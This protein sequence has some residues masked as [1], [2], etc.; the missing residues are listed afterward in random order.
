MIGISFGAGIPITLR[1]NAR[2]ELLSRVEAVA[3]EGMVRFAEGA[4]A[5]VPVWTGYTRAIWEGVGEYLSDLG[6]DSFP[7]IDYSEA[8]IWYKPYWPT[9]N[10]TDV[11]AEL[12]DEQQAEGRALGYDAV[13]I[14]RTNRSIAFDIFIPAPNTRGGQNYEYMEPDWDSLAAGEM[15]FNNYIDANADIDINDLIEFGRF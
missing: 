14:R 3:I 8:D 15:A 4:A 6:A 10:Y 1:G 2:K 9:V 5:A 13:R 12:P 7:D 11:P